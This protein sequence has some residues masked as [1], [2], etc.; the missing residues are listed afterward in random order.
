MDIEYG[1]SGEPLYY[2]YD[3][4]YYTAGVA[5]GDVYFPY[6]GNLVPL[7]AGTLITGDMYHNNMARL[8][9]TEQE[10]PPSQLPTNLVVGSSQK[11][12]FT[13]SYRN[14]DHFGKWRG[15]RD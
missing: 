8:S 3:N 1:Q 11:D 6:Q 7:P 15:R 13:G 10:T 12:V 14:E 5:S 9:T 2:N 4:K